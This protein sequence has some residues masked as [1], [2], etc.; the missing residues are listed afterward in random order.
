METFGGFNNIEIELELNK[1][2]E[3]LDIE[4][5]LGKDVIFIE[6]DTEIESTILFSQYIYKNLR[7]I[8]LLGEL[9]DISWKCKGET[10]S[11]AEYCKNSV[12]R[13][14][15][16][17]ILLEYNRGDDPKQI[18]SEAIRTV[19]N[20]LERTQNL[21]RIIPFDSRAFFLGIQAQGDLYSNGFYNYISS[22]SPKKTYENIGLTF[23][24]PFF[25]KCRND[26]N[27]F[28]IDDGECYTD[29]VRVYLGNIYVND[30][31]KTFHNI[32]NSFGN[33]SFEDL[34]QNLKDAWKKVTDFYVLKLLLK[35][36]DID[37]YI[38]VLGEAHYN[39]ISGILKQAS[40]Q[41]NDH[42]GNKKSCIN[43]YKTYRI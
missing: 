39:N 35:Q 1:F 43:I 23:I 20:E 19:Y 17:R 15:R 3:K 33:I 24:E 2:L 10:I 38:V 31:T 32:A 30:I 27:L 29:D 25:S 4:K 28:K 5:K 16:C 41:L 18:G 36:D 26:K 6:T 9:H 14:P 40:K 37:D 22:N 8:T 12:E 21:N 34:H 42:K 7:L 11:I 13:N